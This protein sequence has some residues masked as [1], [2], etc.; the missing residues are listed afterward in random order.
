MKNALVA[1]AASTGDESDSRGI[2]S[3][4]RDS[5]RGEFFATRTGPKNEALCSGRVP[6]VRPGVHGPKK[7]AQPLK[8]F[9]Y[10]GRKTAAQL[11][12]LHMK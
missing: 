12:C 4:Q 10:L 2:L 1:C 9:C 3:Q 6:H 8:R 7:K 11:R 5:D